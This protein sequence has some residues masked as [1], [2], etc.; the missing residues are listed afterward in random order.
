MALLEKVTGNIIERKGILGRWQSR[1]HQELVSPPR[2]QLH[3]QNLSD[4]SIQE[5]WSLLKAY[6]L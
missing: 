6:N 2:Q 3:W 5:F 4:R 1:K